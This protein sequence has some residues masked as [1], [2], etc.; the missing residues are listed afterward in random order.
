MNQKT[1]MIGMVIGVVLIILNFS[2]NAKLKNESAVPAQMVETPIVSDPNSATVTVKQAPTIVEQKA[3]E[4][5][6]KDVQ[7]KNSK[8]EDLQPTYESHMNNPILVR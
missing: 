2:M 4:S 8:K 5:V 6:S 1:L 7:N 3:G